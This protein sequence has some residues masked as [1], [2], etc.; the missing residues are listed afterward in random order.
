MAVADKLKALLKPLVTALGY[1]F[2]GLEFQTGGGGLLRLYI[3]EPER[4]I[5][6][7][8]CESV[9]R[10][11]SALLDVEDPISGDYTLEVSSPGLDRPLFE[12]ADFLRF[13]GHPVRVT[14]MAPVAGRRRFRGKLVGADDG[15]I[16]VIVD[17]QTYAIELNNI[18]KARLDPEW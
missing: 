9:S 1:E 16:E 14:S 15:A 18:G 6:I 10:E 11:V 17:G 8:D 3:D 13:V 5:G 12:A 2:V 4:G 7:E